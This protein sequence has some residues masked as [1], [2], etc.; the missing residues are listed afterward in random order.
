MYKIILLFLAVPFLLLLS[1]LNAGADDAALPVFSFIDHADQS[2][3]DGKITEAIAD[4]SRA[5]IVDPENRPAQNQLR[6]MKSGYILPA[7]VKI[8]LYFFDDLCV[9]IERLNQQ[10]RYYEAKIQEFQNT[11][12]DLGLVLPSAF[13]E[14]LVPVRAAV[15]ISDAEKERLTAFYAN[16]NA[17]PLDVLNQSLQL[18]RVEADRRLTRLK[19]EYLYWRDQQKT[20]LSFAHHGCIVQNG[21][22]RVST[23]G[24]VVPELEQWQKEMAVV[25]VQMN[26]LKEALNQRDEKIASLNQDIMDLSLSVAQGQQDSARQFAELKS[27]LLEQQTLLAQ[28]AG[29]LEIYHGKLADTTTLLKQKQSAVVNLAGQLDIARDRLILKDRLLAAA[30]EEL[31]RLQT[32]L[33]L[34]RQTMPRLPSA[35]SSQLRMDEWRVRFL[36]LRSRLAD[37][38]ETIP[39]ALR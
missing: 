16:T 21:S 26:Q 7:D 5:M 20:Q 34:L 10:N 27:D 18:R 31:R 15:P 23:A 13:R 37:L 4:L 9:D 12:T 11:L 35:Q 8:R 14:A 39:C 3:R 17:D 30:Q 38:K 29:I 2:L 1:A 6:A 24:S 19:E 22:V 25:R 32:E 28:N 33:N 36:S